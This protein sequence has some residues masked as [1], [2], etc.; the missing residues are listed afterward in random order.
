M[1]AFLAAYLFVAGSDDEPCFVLGGILKAP[2]RPAVVRY[3]ETE[4]EAPPADEDLKDFPELDYENP[5]DDRTLA[6]MEGKVPKSSRKLKDIPGTD[7][8]KEN[9]LNEE[10]ERFKPIMKPLLERQMT[11]AEIAFVLNRRLDETLHLFFQ[12]PMHSL[13]FT[14]RVVRNILRRARDPPDE[15]G[16]RWMYRLRP[17]GLPP[18][19]PG[20]RYQAKSKV[21]LKRYYAEVPALAPWP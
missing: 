4:M 3:A 5:P 13:P 21:G 17:T 8:Y 7:R 20:A 6:Q 10:A 2:I 18:K 9:Q 15:G 11:A 16:L 14:P 1:A 19:A 12:P